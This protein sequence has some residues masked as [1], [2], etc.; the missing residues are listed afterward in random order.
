MAL[1]HTLIMAPVLLAITACETAQENPNYK[2]SS[3]YASNV[4]SQLAQNSRHPDRIQASHQQAAAPVRYENSTYTTSTTTAHNSNII[5]AS[6]Q[7]SQVNGTYTRVNGDCFS[8]NRTYVGTGL[9]CNPAPVQASTQQAVITPAYTP[10][11][12]VLANHQAAPTNEPLQRVFAQPVSQPEYTPSPTEN[13][14]SSDS[15]GT[16]GYEVFRQAQSG[17]QTTV[18]PSPTPQSVGTQPLSVAAPPP[19]YQAYQPPAQPVSAPQY[20][21][22]QPNSNIA[23]STQAYSE[24]Q[25]TA[26]VP[27]TTPAAVPQWPSSQTPL[28][29]G[30]IVKPAFKSVKHCNYRSQT[31]K[32]L[33][34][35][36]WV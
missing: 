20:A 2:H 25:E 30:Y 3:T 7:S 29:G 32:T 21:A 8:Q 26:V 36:S 5:Q 24:T 1:R 22:I 18:T 19:A 28:G 23:P 12:T 15:V 14:Y 31:A 34:T 16:P 11:H 9:D 10:N 33:P 35:V 27:V 17:T 4:P 13:T 6:S